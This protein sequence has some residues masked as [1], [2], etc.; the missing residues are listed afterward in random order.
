M[1]RCQI[2]TGVLND[3]LDLLFRLA[4]LLLQAPDELVFVAFA[5]G[6]IIVGKFPVGLLEFSL[7]DVPVTFDLQF[8]HTRPSQDTR[9]P[10]AS[11]SKLLDNQRKEAG[12]EDQGEFDSLTVGKRLN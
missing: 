10:D 6:K 1:S 7:D 11:A 2:H 12:Q 3:A 4:E 5:V 9:A 8:V